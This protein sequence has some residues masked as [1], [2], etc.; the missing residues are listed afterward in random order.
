V[1]ANP[2]TCHLFLNANGDVDADEDP[3]CPLHG[4]NASHDPA[5]DTDESPF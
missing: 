2:C 3:A 1:N 5:S 4:A